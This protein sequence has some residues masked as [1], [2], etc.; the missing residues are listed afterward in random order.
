MN[1]LYSSVLSCS[2]FFFGAVSPSI[3]TQ[4]QTTN[5]VIV[6][7]TPT[8]TA[9]VPENPLAPGA[10]KVVPNKTTPQYT[11]WTQANQG[12]AFDLIQKI[13]EIWQKEGINDYMIFGKNSENSDFAWE[14]VPY[15]DSGLTFWKQFKVLFNL[16]F[17][18]PT[19]SLE[20]RQ[21]VASKLMNPESLSTGAA[22]ISALSS[23]PDAFCNP[24][25][26]Q[27]QRVFEGKHINVLYNYAPIAIDENKLHFMM[28]PKEH[29][30]KFTDLTREEY[31]EVSEL[32]QKLARY[33]GDKGYHTTYMFNKTGAEAG[34]TVPHWHQHLI[35]TAT[36]TQE[37]Y[38]KL[39]VLKNMI[40][41]SSPL[42]KAELNER[43]RSLKEELHPV[44][45]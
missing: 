15:H 32:E 2:H 14:V 23:K 28:V 41:G 44:L 17:G 37:L 25:V 42:P 45:S 24:E 33:Y 3:E 38:G 43:V 7:Q 35:F 10:L 36:K 18:A 4:A 34:Q 16:T 9:I 13:I 20:E 6:F 5:E 30:E 12:E 22:K 26:I 40:F 31:L 27:K 19:A 11:D 8:M 21:A 29:H 1:T 39:I